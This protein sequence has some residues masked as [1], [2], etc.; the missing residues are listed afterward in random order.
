MV[1]SPGKSA[2]DS[3]ATALDS[4]MPVRAP[5]AVKNEVRHSLSAHEWR[6]VSRA[7]SQASMSACIADYPTEVSRWRKLVQFLFGRKINAALPDPHLQKVR[8][9]ICCARV[10]GR[11]SEADWNEVRALGYSEAQIEALEW[12][13]IEGSPF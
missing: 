7:F 1:A 12:L 5:K 3:S 13:A 11:S 10:H 2:R 4:F 8:D 6:A 9:F